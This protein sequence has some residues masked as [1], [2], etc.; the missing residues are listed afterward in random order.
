MTAVTRHPKITR[1]DRLGFRVDRQTKD[2]IERAAELQR[3]KVS[4]FCVTALADAA[5]K[6]IAEH[7]TLRLSEADRKAFFDILMNPP[8]PSE[9]LIRAVAEHRRRVVSIDD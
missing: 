5:R 1:E 9:R 4:D 3:R 7:E 6:T 8:E 2:M